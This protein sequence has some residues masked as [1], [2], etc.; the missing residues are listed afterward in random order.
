MN[1]THWFASMLALGKTAG[2]VSHTNGESI[3]ACN[4]KYSLFF[5]K[6]LWKAYLLNSIDFSS[7]WVHK[8][9]NKRGSISVELNHVVWNTCNVLK[10]KNHRLCIIYLH[11]VSLND[12]LTLVRPFE[13]FSPFHVFFSNFACFIASCIHFITGVYFYWNFTISPSFPL[14]KLFCT[15]YNNSS[16]QDLKD[17]KCPHWNPLKLLFLIAVPFN[18]KFMQFL[19]M[20]FNLVGKA[21]VMCFFTVFYQMV[22]FFRCGL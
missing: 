7:K 17:K 2:S 19:L 15:R 9:I 6:H 12:S 14:I 22:P 4:L 11:L 3:E 21:S 20:G 18:C 5:L 13:H 16:S 8:Q 10:K 1:G